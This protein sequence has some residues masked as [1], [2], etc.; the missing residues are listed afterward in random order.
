MASHESRV[1]SHESRVTN[2]ESRV[3]SHESQDPR[4][5]TRDPRQGF[6]VTGTDTGVGKTVVACALLKA[7]AARGLRAIGM[8]PV[9]SGAEPAAHGLIHDDVERLIAASNLAAPREHVNPYCFLP[10]IAPHIAARQAGVTIDLERIERSFRA[11]A[12][13]A[14]VVIVEGAGGFRV[15]LGPATDT[16]Q[17][18]ARLALPVVLVVGMRLGCLNHALLTAEAIAARGLK[19]AG[20]IANYIDPQMMAAGDNVRALEE[21]I[22]APLLARIAFAST[23]DLVAIAATLNIGKLL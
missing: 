12:A 19:L 8:K 17:L 6:F 15:P 23:P 3:A 5:E 14:D 13:R 22:T 1:T 20:W 16:A 7:F 18:A 21:R 10:P 4:P 2:E 11:L 9:A